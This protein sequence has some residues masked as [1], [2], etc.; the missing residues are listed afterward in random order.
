MD[1]NEE[2]LTVSLLRDNL[3]IETVPFIVR[4]IP[5][6][7]GVGGLGWAWE[8]VAQSPRRALGSALNCK[9]NSE[10]VVS[11]GEL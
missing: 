2:G 11:G 7:S 3:G 8:E 4:H 6:W 5:A 1:P 9:Y 10:E